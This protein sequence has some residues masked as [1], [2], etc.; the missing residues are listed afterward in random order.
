MR[1]DFSVRRNVILAVLGVLLVADAAMAVYSVQMASS[2]MSP[3]QELTVR[4]TQVKL[5]KADV[6]RAAAIRRD[7]PKTKSD[8]DQFEGSLPPAS[9]GYSVISSELADLGREAGLKISELGFHAKEL[10]GRGVTEIAVDAT[11]TGEYKSVVKFLNGMQRSKNYYVVD[12]L[13]LG[14]D[15]RTLQQRTGQ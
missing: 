5:L 7:M 15:S 4:A 8:C 13:A 11:V 6:E 1:R 10:G 9:G 12:S 3:Q 2:K 14:T